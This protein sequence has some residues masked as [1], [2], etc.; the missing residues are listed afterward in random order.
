MADVQN[1]MPAP[2]TP[3]ASDRDAGPPPVPLQRTQPQARG[4]QG[5]DPPGTALQ[6]PQ[7]EQDSPSAPL[8]T[9]PAPARRERRGGR[10]R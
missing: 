1:G 5:H 7:R 9:L 2:S 6:G 4:P 10:H 3:A 8:G